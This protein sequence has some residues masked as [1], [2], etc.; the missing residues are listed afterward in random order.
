MVDI[1]KYRK[2]H[3]LFVEGH[4]D[5]QVALFAVLKMDDLVDRWSIL[6]SAYWINDDNRKDIF[7]DLI[8]T[9][10]QELDAEELSEIARIV[11]YRPEEHLIQLF[12]EQFES[13]QHIKEDAKVNGNVVHEG[14]I[15]ALNKEIAPTQPTSPH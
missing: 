5:Q 8:A 14:Y 2:V 10:Q 7:S 15:V 6:V 9:L 1:I 12:L 3:R 4:S 11:F 13:G